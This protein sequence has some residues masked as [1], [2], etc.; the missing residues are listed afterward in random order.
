[1]EKQFKLKDDEIKPLV[2]I[3]G[4]CVATDKITV[5]GMKIVYMYR[6]QADE[7]I[8]NDT[9][10]RFLSG[11]ETPEYID[12]FDNYSIFPINTIANYD[13]AIIPYLNSPVGS[14]FERIE[15]MDRFKKI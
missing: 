13:E 3:V 14:E 12:D 5:E 8:A 11:S 15:G 2:K 9:G 4:G 10:W 1:M 7:D 6:E